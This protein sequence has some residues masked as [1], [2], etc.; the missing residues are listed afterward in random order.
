MR[1]LIFALMATSSA[2]ASFSAI[3]ARSSSVISADRSSSPRPMC[4]ASASAPDTSYPPPPPPPPSSSSSSYS[5]R[6]SRSRSCNCLRVCCCATKASCD[7]VSCSLRVATSRCA[8]ERFSMRACCARTCARAAFSSRSSSRFLAAVAEAASS[9]A[10]AACRASV[11]S[12][13]NSCICSRVVAAPWSTRAEFHCFCK[14]LTSRRSIRIC[15]AALASVSPEVPE[16]T[17]S[18]GTADAEPSAQLAAWPASTTLLAAR[19]CLSSFASERKS[20]ASLEFSS[21]SSSLTSCSA[22]KLS[23]Y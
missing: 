21:R 11:A 13:R 5:G 2:A 6:R 18:R 22:A 8:A 3:H 17:A 9:A 14:N 23:R 1:K 15:E 19:S 7:F 16:S 10:V 12:S 4:A 20:V